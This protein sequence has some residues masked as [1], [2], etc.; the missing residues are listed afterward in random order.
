[1]TDNPSKSADLAAVLQAFAAGYSEQEL[2]RVAE[3]APRDAFIQEIAA[4][5]GGGPSVFSLKVI[6]GILRP[7]T[8]RRNRSQNPD[9]STTGDLG[10]YGKSSDWA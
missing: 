6:E 7:G 2:L 4:A 9:P 8:I 10:D 1:M 3:L 5:G